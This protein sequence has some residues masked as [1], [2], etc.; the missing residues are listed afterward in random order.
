MLS[1]IAFALVS[2]FIVTAAAS[3]AQ[4][5]VTSYSDASGDIDPN[6]ATAGGTLDL[7]GMEISNT[8]SDIVFRLTVNGD[9]ASTDWGKFMVGI[10]K[11]GGS[12]TTSGNGWNRPINM[13]AAGGMTNWLGGWVNGGGGGE[14][15]VFQSAAWSRVGATWQGN[16]PGSYSIAAGA[17]STVTWTVS[18]TSMGL[19]LG[20]TF[21]F[22]AYSSGGSDPDSAVDALANP[23]ISVTGWNG[24]YTSGGSN[25]IY[26]YTVVPA[27]GAVALLGLAGLIA[28]RRRRA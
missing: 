24:P 17:T 26:S 4:A 5:Q 28:G 6:I 22:D 15:Y 8:A 9:I 25:P 12:G 14:S 23:N 11:V 7:L 21:L 1:R 13:N 27:P 10:A 3:T 19:S 18:L 16:F 2:G 20:D